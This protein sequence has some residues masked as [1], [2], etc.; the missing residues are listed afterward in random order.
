MSASFDGYPVVEQYGD[1]VFQL[2]GR[3]GIGD[4]DAS[5]VSFQKQR[6]SHARFAEADDQ[7][8]LIL[9]IHIEFHRLRR[10]ARASQ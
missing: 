3:L 1:F 6:G 9:Q 5:A 10:T 4:G 8:A 7:N 2:V